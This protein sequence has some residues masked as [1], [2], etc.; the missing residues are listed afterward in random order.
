MIASFRDCWLEQ[1]FCQDKRS[2]HIPADAEDRI[3][4][5]LQLL[6][7]A[8][9][10]LDLRVPPSNHF[11]RLKGNLQGWHSIRVTKSWRLM[12]QWDGSSGQASKVYLDNHTYR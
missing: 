11:E 5:K 10:D 7:D 2:K 9:N 8:A 4:R 3:F 6:D 12:F 1:F